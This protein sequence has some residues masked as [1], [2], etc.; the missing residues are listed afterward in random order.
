M[1]QL[2]KV[3]LEVIGEGRTDIGFVN[4]PDESLFGPPDKGVVPILVHAL[5]D[6]PDAMQVKRRPYSSLQGKTRA[7][8]VQFAKRQSLYNGSH[9]M[10]FVLDSEGD[11]K[12]RVKELIAGRDREH[13]DY[14]AAIGV[15]H[16][17]IEAWLLADEQAIR[18]AL[19]LSKTP[20]IPDQ[21]ERLPAPLKDRKHNPKTVLRNAVG[22]GRNELSAKEK[23][24]IAAA[25]NDMSLLRNRCPEGFA[26]FADE[27]ENRIRPLF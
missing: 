1:M 22:E 26:P 18:R 2:A 3:V 11:L 16:P 21:P 19:D 23:D 9:G 20:D 15:A 10:V 24:C 13:T 4:C 14:P 7:Q 8:K 5:C 6:K 12:G 27:V 25:M 17:C